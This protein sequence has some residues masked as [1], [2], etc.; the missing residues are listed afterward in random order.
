[1][2]ELDVRLPVQGH[3]ITQA[4]INLH[5]GDEV[6]ISATAALGERDK[7]RETLDSALAADPNNVE[8]LTA[9]AGIDAPLRAVL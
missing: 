1:M 4:V 2:L 3:N 6:I 8:A 7:A 5:C 9:R